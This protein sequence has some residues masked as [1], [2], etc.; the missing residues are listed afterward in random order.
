[1]ASSS[2]RIGLLVALLSLA[3]SASLAH[4]VVV[5]S[6]TRSVT[7]SAS[8]PDGTP[9]ADTR[10]APGF[11][12]FSARARATS[13]PTG[14][15]ASALIQQRSMIHHDSIHMLVDGL[16]FESIASGGEANVSSI[17]DVS[18]DLTD[19]SAYELHYNGLVSSFTTSNGTLSD[20]TGIILELLPVTD[21]TGILGPGR[22]R[23]E[24]FA[25]GRAAQNEFDAVTH[26]HLDLFFMPV[27]EPA[28][29]VLLAAGLAALRAARG[30]ARRG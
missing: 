23:L 7:A 28:T 21:R 25:S 11:A 17:F 5:V 4:P 16:A 27:P 14:D 3:S 15:P 30:S 19:A 8:H 1:M 13:G 22:Y 9:S 24:I 20:A 2:A 6:Q 12:D 18:F 10:S 29:A 26:Q